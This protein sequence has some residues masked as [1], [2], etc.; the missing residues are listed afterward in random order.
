MFLMNY[1]TQYCIVC[2]KLSS[3]ALNHNSSRRNALTRRLKIVK[4]IINYGLNLADTPFRRIR[5]SNLTGDK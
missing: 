4:Y 2:I 3:C 5:A 1:I